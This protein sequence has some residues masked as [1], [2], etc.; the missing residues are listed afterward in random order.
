MIARGALL[1]RPLRGSGAT[2]VVEGA[3]ERVRPKAMTV[4]AIL[5]SLLPLLWAHGTGSEVMQRIAV[6]M[7]GGMASSVVLTLVVIPAL[8]SVAKGWRLPRG[9]LKLKSS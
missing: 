9:A 2:A 6:P 4:A 1:A 5:G 8:Y 7:I 3:V